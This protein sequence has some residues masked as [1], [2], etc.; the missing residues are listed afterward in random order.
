MHEQLMTKETSQS[1]KHDISL[2][3]L[4]ENEVHEVD[5]LQDKR[6]VSWDSVE[7]P[8]GKTE[9]PRMAAVLAALDPTGPWTHPARPRT[10]SGGAA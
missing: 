10:T 2:A 3:L 7:E 4:I 8:A 9:P 6:W 5:T 1:R